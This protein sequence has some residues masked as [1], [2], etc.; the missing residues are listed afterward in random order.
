MTPT[1]Y[2]HPT[3]QV[4]VAAFTASKINLLPNPKHRRKPETLLFVA[5]RLEH[6]KKL[7]LQTR[8]PKH[9]KHPKKLEL[10]TRN[11]KPE[12]ETRNPA[13]AIAALSLL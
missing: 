7:E 3:Y 8:N 5:C 10:Q 1:V 13:F 4:T 9:P 2:L 12:T 6:P 11:P